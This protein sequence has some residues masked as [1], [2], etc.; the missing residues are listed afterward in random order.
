M[1]I[2]TSTYGKFER[3][4]LKPSL[5]RLI[6]ICQILRM[7]VENSLRGAV[8]A[9]IIAS[10]APETVRYACADS[11][12]ALRLYHRF[13][14]WFDRYLPAHH[15]LV[16]TVESPT[17]VYCGLMKYNGL[18]MDKSAMIQKQVECMDRL[19]QVRHQIR[20]LIGDVD[21]GA[22]ANTQAFKRYLFEDL[23]LPVLKT[24]AKSKEAADD[25]AL[26]MLSEWC[27]EHRPELVSLFTLI[28]EYRKHDVKKLL[29][30]YRD[31]LGLDVS[32]HGINFLTPN[33][34][35]LIS[36]N[37]ESGTKINFTVDDLERFMEQLQRK[38]VKVLCEVKSTNF[39]KLAQIEDPAGN[40][41]ELW[42]PF[43][44]EYTCMVRQEII[45]FNASK[46]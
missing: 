26:I 43:D 37:S 4:V 5:E 29:V 21:I 7:S 28:Q 35:T 27:E 31:V 24:T 2:I 22:N 19:L 9:N 15:T 14:A 34:F 44:T 1:K 12:F 46:W 17:A 18:L 13:N 33:H 6:A 23:K 16:E 42:E 41:V 38:G 3:G 30:W 36:F 11:E 25:Q 20:D 39:G 40:I 45:E 32:E 10:N 8:N